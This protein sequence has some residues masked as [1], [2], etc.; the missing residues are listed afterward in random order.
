VSLDALHPAVLHHIVN[1]LGWRSLRPFQEDAIAPILAGEHCLLL[2][3]TAGGKTEATLFPLFSRLL[4]ESWPPLS[5]LYVCPLR[6]LLN[7][8]EPRV[9]GFAQFLGRT[10]RLWHGDVTEAARRQ[11]KREP[12]DVLLTTPESL[13]VMLVSRAVDHTAL[14]GN[15]RAV[16]V[17]ELHAFAGDDRGWHLLAVLER[18]SRVAGRP[19]QRIG[20]SATIGNPEDLLGWLAG[21]APGLRRVIGRPMG[22]GD[23]EVRADAVGSLENAATVVTRLH[24]DA[25]RLVFCDS[26]SRVEE[27]A[28]RLREQGTETYVSH[29]SLGVDERRRA[30]Q[31]FAEKTGCVI[32]ATSTLELGIDVGDLDHVIQID[33]PGTVSAFLQRMGRTG[34]RPE[35]VR[36]LLFVTTSDESLLIAAGLIALW[37]TGFVE[38]VVPPPLPHHVLAQ[39]ILA[40]TF[41]LGGWAPERWGEWVGGAPGLGQLRSAG[42][43]IVSHMLANGILFSDAGVTGLGPE[44]DRRFAGKGFLDVLSVFTSEPLFAVLHGRSHVGAVD[45]ASFQL[46]Q[47]ETPILLLG[48]RPWA[49]REVDWNDRI[50]YVEPVEIKGRSLWPGAGQPLG[51]AL[52]RSIRDVLAGLDLDQHLTE[53][54]RGLLGH[55]RDEY[56]WIGKDGTVLVRRHGERAGWWTFA[57]LRAN[58]SLSDFLTRKGK[59]VYS[60]TN[61]AVSMDPSVD[62]AQLRAALEEAKAEESGVVPTSL[63]TESLASLKFAD[64][65]PAE[66]ALATLQ[67]RLA[68]PEAVS[69]VVAE[70]VLAVRKG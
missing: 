51:F 15:L 11:I 55:L 69:R 41:Q 65:M 22:A 17:D 16:V 7:N 66:L 25:K 31:A 30:E 33:A 24:R 4:Q 21:S 64:C 50:A 13:E 2:A 58:A 9:A 67:A 23:A 29:G 68:D 59:K 1:S 54:A 27:L 42:A 18:I 10:A 47:G 26:R 57:G 28:F 61:F 49:V 56:S 14:F 46:K 53:R 43:A 63:A 34:R 48:G 32:V 8:L 62:P 39:Q 12:P 37:K 70:P 5:V 20:L 60:R 6:A 40:L 45:G 44:G 52:C 35:A 19:L 36:N 38:P 3:P